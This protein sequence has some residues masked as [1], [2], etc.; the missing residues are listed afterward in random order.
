MDILNSLSRDAVLS[1]GGSMTRK[2]SVAKKERLLAAA[3]DVFIEKGFRNTTI[4]EI[5]TR[6]EA[7]ISAVNYHFGSKEALYQEA[8]RHSFTESLRTYP[9]D[10]GVGAAAPPAARLRGQLTA[11]IRRISDEN[12][13]DFFISQ[14]ELVNPTGLLQSVMQ[15]ELIPLRQQ[16]LA[17]V[18]ELLGPEATDQEVHFTELCIISMCIH[19][20][21]MQRIAQRA[22]DQELPVLVQEIE[23]FA[24]HVVRF[25]LAGINAL[26]KKGSNP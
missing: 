12:N 15:T 21:V 25:A 24:D 10:G 8:W 9:M 11:L 16:T 1:I 6:A 2:K 7:N 14:M 13:K 19:P 26:R 5:C 18:R 23:A 22:K 4:A 17:L 20:M 3:G